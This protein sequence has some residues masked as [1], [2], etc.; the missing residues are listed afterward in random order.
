MP[1]CRGTSHIVLG[2]GVASGKAGKPTYS[3]KRIISDLP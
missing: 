1:E 2:V 3:L